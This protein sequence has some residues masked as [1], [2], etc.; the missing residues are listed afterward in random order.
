ME[1]PACRERPVAKSGT[2]LAPPGV[3]DG[4]GGVGGQ[5]YLVLWL[6]LDELELLEWLEPELLPCEPDE[7]DE[8]DEPDE[9][10]LL[11]PAWAEPTA[12]CDEE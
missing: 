4:F 1:H 3:P 10:L 11:M 8:L 7:P 12:E 5:G 9:P 2:C 6:E